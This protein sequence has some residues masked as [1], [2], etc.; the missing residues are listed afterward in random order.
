MTFFTRTFVS[1]KVIISLVPASLLP[2]AV[3]PHP[4]FPPRPRPPGQDLRQ[5]GVGPGVP[6]LVDPGVPV[7]PGALPLRLAHGG[8]AGDVVLDA[9][10]A[11]H[12][13]AGR[14]GVEC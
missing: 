10:R 2:R 5:P 3:Y 8:V 13:E 1:N 7:H 9:G 4:I 11:D 12:D 14:A 6:G